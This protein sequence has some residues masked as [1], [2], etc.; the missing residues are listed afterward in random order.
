VVRNKCPIFV[1]QKVV[2]EAGIPVDF[3]INAADEGEDD[4][5]SPAFNTEDIVPS[6]PDSSRAAARRN[7]LQAELEQ[8]VIAEEYE[9]A[10]E[11]RD[12]LVLLDKER[13]KDPSRG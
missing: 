6:K 11:I 8:A 5:V 10:A 13:G 7:A 4:Q 2:E 3:I 9:R 12:I 1:S